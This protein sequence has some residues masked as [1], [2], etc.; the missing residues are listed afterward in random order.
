MQSQ[1]AVHSYVSVCRTEL[2]TERC[3]H[4][5][6]VY[7]NEKLTATHRLK[8]NV[9]A[10]L[11]EPPRSPLLIIRTVNTLV[12]ILLVIAATISLCEFARHF[13]ILSH[14]IKRY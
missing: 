7:E 1:L 4:T 5:V 12:C 8:P 9:G 6:L 14:T 13:A 11:G 10:I 2:S 3:V